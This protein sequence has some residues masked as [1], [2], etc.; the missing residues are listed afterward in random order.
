MRQEGNT[1]YFTDDDEFYEWC[2]IPQLKV[3]KTPG[4]I[5]FTDFEFSPQ[6]NDAVLGNMEFIIE[7]KNSK[8]TKRQHVSYRTNTKKI[9]NLKQYNG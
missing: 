6:Y 4:G 9:Q 8:I 7:D 3:C 1:L 2:V 5:L